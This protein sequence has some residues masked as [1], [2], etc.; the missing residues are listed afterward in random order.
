MDDN[1]AD[2]GKKKKVRFFEIFYFSRFQLFFGNCLLFAC[3]SI[4][5]FVTLYPG[6]SCAAS[7]TIASVGSLDLVL[8][9]SSRLVNLQSM[10][11]YASAI[12]PCRTKYKAFYYY[13]HHHYYYYYDYCRY[14]HCHCHYY[15]Y[16][17]RLRFIYLR[18]PLLDVHLH[19][20]GMTF[21]S[22]IL[23]FRRH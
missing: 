20:L 2:F 10:S 5:I 7:N 4:F 16:W 14:C 9:F 15:Y 22:Q 6:F 17:I 3:F 18:H 19:I 13:Y 23:L 1:R 8:Q 21:Y 11:Y 12:S